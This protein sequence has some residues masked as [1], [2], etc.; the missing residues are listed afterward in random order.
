MIWRQ[1]LQAYVLASTA[2]ALLS[3]GQFF[4][5]DSALG[6]RISTQTTVASLLGFNGSSTDLAMD[7]VRTGLIFQG[8]MALLVIGV[9]GAVVARPGW[10][11]FYALIVLAI[12]SYA[13]YVFVVKFL[14]TLQWV[15]LDITFGINSSDAY[16][17]L[18]WFGLAAAI[19]Y[20]LM[21]AVLNKS[22]GR[23]VL[24]RTR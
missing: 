18:I 7:F 19:C 13:A 2:N 4:A 1:H 23:M 16:S 5:V 20:F 3:L 15:E 24:E 22:Y 11:W 17:D 8:I 10:K 6:I 14:D 21:I 9:L 12:S